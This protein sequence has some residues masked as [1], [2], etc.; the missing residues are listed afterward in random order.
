MKKVLGLL[1]VLVMALG[2]FAG[3]SSPAEEVAPEA[4]SEA[5]SEAA[6]EEEVEV[7]VEDIRVAIL[8]QYHGYML[9]AAQ[10]QGYFAQYGL[11]AS[12]TMNAG[13]A[14]VNEALA[15]NQWD[16][17]SLGGA[18]ITSVTAYDARS[19]ALSC[20]EGI[21]QYFYVRN[22]S[23]ILEVQGFNPD[24]P[25]AYGDPDTVT[26]MTVI[27]TIGTTLHYDLQEY[28]KALGM[29]IEDVEVLN[30]DP[31]PAVTAF[32]SGQGDMLITCPPYAWVID[33][34]EY[35]RAFTVLDVGGDAI[36]TI[37]ASAQTLEDNRDMVVKA[38]AAYLTQIDRAIAEE[39]TIL[40]E[41]E[42]FLLD[43]GYEPSEQNLKDE[44]LKQIMTA[45]D[46]VKYFT[47][48]GDDGLTEAMKIL[49][50][51]AQYMLDTGAI[52]QEQYDYYMENAVD[53]S[54]IVDAYELMQQ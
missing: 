49:G 52:T 32:L 37:V 12:F 3:C 41:F 20:G 33:E 29:S 8:P 6:A 2:L 42:A 10:D 9:Q 44:Y 22:D 38:V 30:M 18:A 48:V 47:E 7:E 19:V 23:P 24:F 51:N 27:T 34:T 4:T 53:S 26:G 13:G 15:S 11:D 21:S 50:Y 25:N 16:I 31:G 36:N 14:P 17:S 40:E 43:N 46:Q 1:L 5:T 54:I 39:A 45:E 28:V 35:T